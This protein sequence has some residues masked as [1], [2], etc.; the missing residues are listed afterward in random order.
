MTPYP[1]MAMVHKPDHFCWMDDLTEGFVRFMQSPDSITGPINLGDP[2]EFTI[3]ELAETVIELTRS[4]S[5]VG[6]H[7]LP[8]DDPRQR[9]PNISAAKE[10]L[11]WQPSVPPAEG[12]FNTI[13]YFKRIVTGVRRP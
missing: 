5:T 7:P 6:Y 2:W 10:R 1:Y 11:N 9:R 13:D 12:L 4:K 8:T 3:L